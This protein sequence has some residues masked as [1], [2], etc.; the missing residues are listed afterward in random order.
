MRT[1]ARDADHGPYARRVRAARPR[2]SNARRRPARHS[3]RRTESS[4]ATGEDAFCVELFATGG[5]TVWMRPRDRFC[6]YGSNIELG[7][8]TMLRQHRPVSILDVRRVRDRETSFA[9]GSA[10]DLR[11]DA[12]RTPSSVVVRSSASQSRSDPM[13]GST[14]GR[15]FLPAFELAHA[16]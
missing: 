10:A 7:D 4:A 13:Y 8:A 5:D 2:E 16:R 1:D 12:R 3:T 14:A 11:P 9:F 15:S 6:D